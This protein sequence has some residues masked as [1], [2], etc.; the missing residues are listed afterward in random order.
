MATKKAVQADDAVQGD[1][2]DRREMR[3]IFSETGHRTLNALLIVSGGATVAFMSFLGAAV[4]EPQLAIR[5]GDGRKQFRCQVIT[6]G[7][8]KHP[9]GQ[10]LR[11]FLGDES[12]NNLLHSEL[13]RCDITP[14]EE[15]AASLREVLLEK[16]WTEIA[17]D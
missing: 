3:A 13:V 14:L 9:H 1:E 5:I 16:G 12:D 2:G 4:Q 15:K 10:E 7:I 11:I 6:A 8:Y 17:A